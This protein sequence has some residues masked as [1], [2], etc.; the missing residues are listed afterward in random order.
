MTQVQNPYAAPTPPQGHGPYAPPAF[1]APGT[2]YGPGYGPGNGPATGY[3]A[4]GLHGRFSDVPTLAKPFTG[5]DI[6]KMVAVMI[7]SSVS[8]MG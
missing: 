7:E 4:P 2:G 8:G 5:A 6:E 3:G 1:P